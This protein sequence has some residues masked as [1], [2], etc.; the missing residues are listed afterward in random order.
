MEYHE[1]VNYLESLDRSR[2]KLGTETTA[3]MLSALGNPH[4]GVDCV[5]IA[6]SNG[7]GSTAVMLER[8]LREADLD[9]GLYT[10][11]DLNDFRER[12]RT[13]G[14]K[15]S[16]DFVRSFTE[17]IKPS[18]SRLRGDGDSPTYFE[19]LTV[20]ALQYFASQDVDV[21][22]L[23]VGIGG[24][25]DA[26]SVVEPV[27]SAVTNVSLEHT[28]VLGETVEEIARDKAQVSP[29]GKRLVT[30][31]VG[32]ALE[33]IRTETAVVT[34]GEAEAD[35]IAREGEMT[36]QV[37]TTVSIRGPEWTVST[38]SPLLGQHQATNAGIAATLARQVANVETG[39]IE[40]GLRS[41]HW[42]GRFEV[43]STDPLVILDGAHNPAACETLSD[44]VDRYEFDGLHL[45]FGAMKEKDHSRMAAALPE[46]DVLHLCQPAVSRAASFDTLTGA[47]ETSATR[48]Q[49]DE[50]VQTAVERALE[51]ADGDDCV[52]VTGSLYVVAEARDRWTQLQ[53]PKQVETLDAAR[54]ILSE[55]SVQDGFTNHVAKDTVTHTFKTRLRE[56]QAAYLQQTMQSIGGTCVVSEIASPGRHVSVVLSGTV[57]QYER[58]ADAIENSELGLSYV[59]ERFGEVISDGEE[60]DR[61]PWDAD[62]AVMGILNVTPDSFYD[63]GQYD[64]VEDAVQRFREMSS[65]GVDIVDVGG[66]STRPGADPIT[67][68][69][70]I[71]RVIPVIERISGTDVP[72]S[73]DTR[74]A[75]VADAALE[76]GADIINDVSGLADPDMR[77][78]AADHDVPVVVMHSVDAP[79]DPDR[80]TTYDDVVEDVIR[81]LS[82]RVLLA[83]RAG[84]DRDQIIVDPGLG[85]G[86]SA[87]ECFELVDRLGELRALGC[88]IMVGHSHK[89]MFE[90]V[91]CSLDERL[92]PTVATTTMAAERGADIVRVHDVAENAAA[93]RT[94]REMATTD[95]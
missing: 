8:V 13:N 43:M 87:T 93:I 48:I 7:K 83:E 91:D 23:E 39:A 32:D 95:R 71:E 42:P 67:V 12:I 36:S 20:L 47:F 29:D 86:K 26:T 9:V 61:Y 82:Q 56:K 25:H 40:R 63:G 57:A 68:E 45:V 77:F 64:Q 16:K 84:L 90:R 34:V 62:T 11:P 5:Q 51:S 4:E 88:P 2:P 22:I 38:N 46:S 35:I 72:V 17:E 30:S 31:A 55:A 19:V 81:E 44:L 27:A 24:R 18:L 69:E 15:V 92:L 28:D 50:T 73:I 60:A 21:A 79:V 1:A 94:V 59:S 80:S 6:G 76:A 49:Q 53:I 75:A 78:V 58:L 10:S 85:F 66:E 52:L 89:S 65:S 41:A 70:E 33:A 74:R 3:R 14:Q 54:S 37:E